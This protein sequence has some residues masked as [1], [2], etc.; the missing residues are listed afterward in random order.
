MSRDSRNDIECKNHNTKRIEIT[1]LIDK[2]IQSTDMRSDFYHYL[3][4]KIQSAGLQQEIVKKHSNFMICKFTTGSWK[5][6][7]I[8]VDNAVTIFN[9]YHPTQS[10]SLLRTLHTLLQWWELEY[11]QFLWEEQEEEILLGS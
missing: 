9:K 5:S 7:E 1:E 2:E 4:W 10:T 11:E 6:I 3:S 8:F